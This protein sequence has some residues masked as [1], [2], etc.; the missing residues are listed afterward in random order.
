MNTLPETSG[1]APVD[2]VALRRTVRRL[3]RGG[4][5][6][7]ER[8]LATGHASLDGLLPAGGL[9]KGRIHEILGAERTLE[10]AA[11]GFT[12]ALAALLQRDAA[13][14][15]GQILWVRQQS[16]SVRG[17][18]IS[19]R[20]FEAFGIDPGRVIAVAA[21]DAA[22]LL[23]G[24]EEGLRCAGLAA[25]VA[26]VR[27]VD[28][29]AG[30][31]LQLAAEAGGVTGLMVATGY[32]AGKAVASAAE[33]RWRVRPAP[34]ADP[35][36]RAVWALDLERSRGGLPA[37]LTVGWSLAEQR[38]VAADPISIPHPGTRPKTRVPALQPNL[39]PKI[40]EEIAA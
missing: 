36:R 34:S 35:F 10:G 21:R 4:G 11:F 33:T 22:E 2:L 15:A 3:E 5:T 18:D 27:T 12:A 1:K 16:G 17:A 7:P 14:A 8:V 20:G 38:F 25:V 30:R 37:S 24:A 23:W 9:L 29:T 28:L 13:E 31:R 39:F 6:A 40:A 26:E 19:G 32:R